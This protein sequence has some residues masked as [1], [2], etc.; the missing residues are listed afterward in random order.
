MI[1]LLAIHNFTNR[2]NVYSYCLMLLQMLILFFTKKLLNLT[3][4]NYSPNE[5]RTDLFSKP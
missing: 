1:E 3:L 4:V 2:Q 5:L